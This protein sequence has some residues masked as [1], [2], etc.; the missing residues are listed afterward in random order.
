MYRRFDLV[1]IALLALTFC[2]SCSVGAGRHES[3]RVFR[4]CDGVVFHTFA[5]PCGRPDR[6]LGGRGDSGGS[7]FEPRPPAFAGKDN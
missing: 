4:Q 1:P 3:A 2:A 7:D 5:V 6:A